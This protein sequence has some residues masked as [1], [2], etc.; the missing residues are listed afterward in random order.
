MRKPNCV[1]RS[2]D[3]LPGHGH[4][5]S[6][7]SELVRQLAER[8]KRSARGAV[9][10]A[11]KWQILPCDALTWGNRKRWPLPFADRPDVV[12]HAGALARVAD[13]HARPEASR[14]VNEE[15]SRCL[16]ELAAAFGARLVLVSTDLVFD[17]A[18]G[19]YQERDAPAPRRSTAAVSWP[20]SKRSWPFRERPFAG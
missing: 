3:A 14:Q 20:P 10:R 9:A 11:E 17:G 2:S 1:E 15:G 12:L 5:R 13:C 4:Q 7:G 16:A 8:G 18:R 6:L 19:N